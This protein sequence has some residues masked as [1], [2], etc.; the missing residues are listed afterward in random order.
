MR[1][2]VFACQKQTQ[3]ACESMRETAPE[4]V[5]EL[6]WVEFR[7]NVFGSKQKS[8]RAWK[9]ESQS[10]K[11]RRKCGTVTKW[12]TSLTLTDCYWS[13][14]AITWHTYKSSLIFLSV[15]SCKQYQSSHH[16]LL[17]LLLFY[18]MC[19]INQR[20]KDSILS[21]APQ[22][23]WRGWEERERACAKKES[24]RQLFLLAGFGQWDSC[25]ES[26]QLPSLPV[27]LSVFVFIIKPRKELRDH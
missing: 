24:A 6:K 19:K 11:E 7:T 13:T 2:G 10:V 4:L 27:T 26:Q 9:R 1:F 12:H 20:E 17:C 5:L 18:G 3:I 15:V 14:V 25:F 16:S 22:D 21:R 8:L 23:D